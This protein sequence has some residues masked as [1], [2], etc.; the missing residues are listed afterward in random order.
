M[1]YV[2][3]IGIGIFVGLLGWNMYL[4]WDIGF[5]PGTAYADTATTSVDVGNA[6]PTVSSVVLNTGSLIQLTEN[7]TTTISCTATI[8]DENGG[9]DV[10][11]ATS[12]IHRSGV[13]TTCSADDNN[14]YQ[15]TS[16]NCVLDAPAGNDRGVTCSADIWFHADPTD[17]GTYNGDT[18]ACKVTGTDSQS[19]SGSNTDGT[20][21]EMETLSALNADS[22]ISY[23][24]L[25]A[26]Q[27]MDPITATTTVTT[28]G[29]ATIDVNVSGTTMTGTGDPIA[30]AQQKYATSSVAYA[31]ATA[32]SGT[33]TSIELESA[34]PTDNSPSNQSDDVLWGLAVPG[35][36]TVGS[37]GGVN[38][39]TAV[40]D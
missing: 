34:K 35:G 9:S 23:G 8:T 32:L 7:A 13:A 1:K 5:S 38:T 29:N 24:T 20:P 30:I 37:Y 31:S 2:G 36:Q 25:G 18:W 17:A 22:S 33:P 28:T 27:T 26:G 12:T 19:A 14:C 21:P 11:S 15:I 39:F 4:A 3:I 6:T 10:S 16:G 40:A